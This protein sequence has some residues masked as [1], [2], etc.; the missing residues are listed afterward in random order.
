MFPMQPRANA[1]LRFFHHRKKTFP[2]YFLRYRCMSQIQKG[3]HKISQL[4]NIMANLSL[5]PP[6]P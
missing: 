3:R 6:N 5:F 1:F 2:V 4:Y